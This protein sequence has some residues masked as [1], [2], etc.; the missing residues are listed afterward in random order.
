MLQQIRRAAEHMWP[1]SRLSSPFLLHLAFFFALVLLRSLL[2]CFILYCCCPFHFRFVTISAV[3]LAFSSYFRWTLFHSYWSSQCG[4]SL[5]CRSHVNLY[6]QDKVLLCSPKGERLSQLG[7]KGEFLSRKNNLQDHEKESKHP[8]QALGEVSVFQKSWP[9]LERD[10]DWTAATDS[11]CVLVC[12][13][14][15]A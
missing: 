9:E 12:Q 5:L 10:R 11:W 15:R 4:T 13:Q 1:L 2:L 14:I 8:L 3:A 6:V 7:G